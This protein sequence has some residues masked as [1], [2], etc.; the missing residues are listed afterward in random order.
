VGIPKGVEGGIAP[1]VFWIMR[2]I[3]PPIDGPRWA[4]GTLVLKK[5]CTSMACD[6]PSFT[7]FR[8][9]RAKNHGEDR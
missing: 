1:L 8:G 3:D 9:P 7:K 6:V 2:F 5:T 4:F